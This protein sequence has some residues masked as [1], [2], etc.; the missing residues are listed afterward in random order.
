ML[1][2]KVAPPGSRMVDYLPGH[3]AFGRPADLHPVTGLEVVPERQVGRE[4]AVVDVG[5]VVQEVLAGTQ[6]EVVRAI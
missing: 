4:A 1:C 6:P 3:L 2:K 5:Q